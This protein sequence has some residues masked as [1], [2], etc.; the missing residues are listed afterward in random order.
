M[1]TAS[2]TT[3]MSVRLSYNTICDSK[4]IGGTA[5]FTFLRRELFPEG[6]SIQISTRKPDT[7]ITSSPLVLPCY[8]HPS[9]SRR[10]LPCFPLMLLAGTFSLMVSPLP[11]SWPWPLPPPFRSEEHTS[12]L[13]SQ[14]NL[15]CR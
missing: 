4:K 6:N 13:Q 2:A 14:P 9:Y 10:T 15:A 11:T 12:E 1:G 7:S 3:L 5:I 8:G